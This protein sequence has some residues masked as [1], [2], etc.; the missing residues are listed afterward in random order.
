MAVEHE[1]FGSSRVRALEEQESEKKGA[2]K[3]TLCGSDKR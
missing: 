1:E 3:M 2:R